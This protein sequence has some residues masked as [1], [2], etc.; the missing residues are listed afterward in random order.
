MTARE[1]VKIFL[2]SAIAKLKVKTKI[3]IQLECVALKYET[4]FAFVVC[5]IPGSR[6]ICKSESDLQMTDENVSNFQLASR[7]NSFNRFCFQVLC[8]YDLQWLY[9]IVHLLV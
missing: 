4:T 8:A 3:A 9:E 2:F 1:R 5:G 6:D 7:L